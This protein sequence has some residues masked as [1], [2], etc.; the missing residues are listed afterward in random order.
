MQTADGTQLYF[1][2]EKAMSETQTSLGKLIT[3]PDQPRDAIHIAVAPVTATQKLSPGQPIGFVTDGDTENVATSVR[4]IGIVDPFLSKMVFE[5]QRFWMFLYPNTIT[6]L[7]HDWTHA[8]FK[9]E[10]QIK[11]A[12]EIYIRHFAD[13]AGLSYEEVL[14]AAK[15]YLKLGEY[16]NQGGR[17]E[18]FVTPPEFWD[19]YEVVTGETVPADE[20]G[21]FFSCSC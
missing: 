11:G 19:H 5:G 6:S 15:D 2:R 4:P 8:A 7:R 9:P 16:L 17:W 18:G 1:N 10:N 21:G 13:E 14:Y 3:S 12:S 20:R